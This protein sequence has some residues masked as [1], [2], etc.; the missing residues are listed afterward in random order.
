MHECRREKD[1]DDLKERY[2]KVYETIHGNG[3]IGLKG[4]VIKLEETVNR[5]D[6]TLMAMDETN[7]KTATALSGL[8]KFQIEW[9]VRE[10]EREKQ[11]LKSQ[12]KR[13][14]NQWLI[15]L[16]ITII[17]ALFIQLIS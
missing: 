5:F 7:K 8:L 15:G 11:K 14:N 4:H 1:I 9:E 16:L 10:K 12:K 3:D 13:Q 17:I 2:V 6:E